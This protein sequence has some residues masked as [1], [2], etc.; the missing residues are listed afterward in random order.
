MISVTATTWA[1]S[2]NNN[3]YYN[4][5]GT[6]SFVWEPGNGGGT[7]TSFAAYQTGSYNDSAAISVNP[8]LNG[9]IGYHSPGMPT[10]SSGNYTLP[11]TSPAVAAGTFVCYS[12][13]IAAGNGMGTQDF[14]GQTVAPV[15]DP[16]TT[17]PPG[18]PNPNIGAFD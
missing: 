13:C 17:I 7:F 14:F 9:V 6:Y 2:S 10:L 1:I 3:L 4:A 16:N 5:A 15:P 11:A 12:T 8:N 18:T